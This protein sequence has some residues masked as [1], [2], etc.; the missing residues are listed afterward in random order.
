M[1][2]YKN[3]AGQVIYVGK[4]KNL[5]NRISSYFQPPIRLGPK[6]ALLVQ[7]I[8]S[9]D[10]ISVTSET[11]AL[12]LE[13]RLIKKFLPQF[14]IISKDD[15]SPFYIH[16]TSETFPK[17][18]LNH[19]PKKSLAG[20]FLNSL[21]PRRILKQFRRIAPY[22][23]AQRPVKRPCFYSHLGLCSPCPGSGTDDQIKTL[24]KKNISRL[25]RLLQGNFKTV[26]ASLTSEMRSASKLQNFETAG[27]L[28]DQ[29]QALEHLL[30]QP[31][32]PDEYLLNPNLLQD[33]QNESVLSLRQILSENGINLP[34]VERIEM[35]DNAHLS[36][37]AAAA[38][39]VVS[40]NGQ[41]D[42]RLYRHFRVKSVKTG[43]DFAMMKEILTRRFKRTDWP[44][45]DLVVLDGGKP[46][47]SATANLPF[48][49]IALAK[50]KETI[51]IP[52]T[53]GKYLEVNLP[54][55]HPALRLLI[56]MRDE[57]HRFSRRL[58]HKM[59]RL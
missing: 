34:K 8:F 35:Y 38:A 19:E 46:Q 29:L 14:N 32:M 12:L 41:I 1:Y 37:T 4:A 39:M 22:C 20:P 51:V 42:H 47:L 48:P 56:A 55:N 25:K 45:P 24:Y 3:T 9:I 31:I 44:S 26:S 15:K 27:Q 59:R 16:I 53:S 6:T 21:I 10:T 40:I 5:K 57:A 2:I 52:R 43:D 50:H 17:P 30:N 28:R 36:G 54:E 58:H 23:I 11:E 49:T 7:N 33:I 13:S 18:V